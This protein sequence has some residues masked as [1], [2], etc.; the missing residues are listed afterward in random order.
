MHKNRKEIHLKTHNNVPHTFFSYQKKRSTH[1]LS[2]KL[3][4][5]TRTLAQ[6]IP[7]RIPFHPNPA[8]SAKISEKTPTSRFDV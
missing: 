7:D 3:S 5:K 2:P 6:S 4:E 8:Q 1:T